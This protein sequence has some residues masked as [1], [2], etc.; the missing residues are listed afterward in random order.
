VDSARIDSDSARVLHRGIAEDHAE[1]V[2]RFGSVNPELRAARAMTRIDAARTELQD[3][4]GEPEDVTDLRAIASD[5]AL[6]NAI[7]IKALL[8]R[9]D[10]RSVQAEGSDGEDA[11][12]LGPDLIEA[13]RI[14][15]TSARD[16][17]IENGRMMLERIERLRDRGDTVDSGHPSR[18]RLRPYAFALDSGTPPGTNILDR[19]ILA[20]ILF[21]GGRP[22]SALAIW[23]GIAA[24]RPDTLEV[25]VGRADVLC[26]L[27]DLES[28]GEAMRTYR[29]LGRGRPGE[30]VPEAT[31]WHAQLNQLL[32]L[33]K[34]GR[35]IDRIAPRI[36]RLRLVDPALGGDRH[37]S[38]FEAL[39]ARMR[40][41]PEG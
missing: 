31:W 38:A 18:R 20:R 4:G 32:I 40:S 29:V 41:R 23:D 7:R 21:E 16:Q 39:R 1:L 12:R 28:M 15:A 27:D 33:E 5:E 35:S 11:L 17:M 34:V 36:E 3:A 25:M 37:S 22:R 24:E 2:G 26:S 13:M 19:M 9:H 14:D 6:E 30:L 8:L 10:M